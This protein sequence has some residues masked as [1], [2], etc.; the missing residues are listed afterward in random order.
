MR[1]KLARLIF[2]ACMGV[3]LLTCGVMTALLAHWQTD[4]SREQLR[5]YSSAL[6]AMAD[7]S[8]WEILR[9]LPAE[10][11]F[12]TAVRGAEGGILWE[13][14]P[15]AEKNALCCT[16]SLA[17][18]EI[19]EVSA[20]GTGPWMLVPALVNILVTTLMLT[21]ILSLLLAERF[22]RKI[23]APISTLNVEN[24]DDAEIYEEMKPFVRRISFQNRQIHQ[25]MDA[26]LEE[27]K[28]Q[29][30]MRREFTA[31]VSHE[32]KTPL[33]SISGFAEII[34]DG[35]VQ[36]K[37]IPHFADTI[38]QEAQRLM[39]LVNDILKLSRLEEG[40]DEILG[41]RETVEL[42]A[43]C[44]EVME[45]LEM[46]A[47]KHGVSMEISGEPVCT[48]GVRNMLDEIVYNV[49]DN[50]IKYNRRGGIVRIRT[51]CTGEEAYVRIEDT[52]I[53]IPEADR[54][55]IFER[56]YRVNKSHSKE[57]GGTGLGLSI[58]KHGMA[59]HNARITLESEEEKG[60]AVG[61]YFIGI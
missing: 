48:R 9:S 36:E 21:V 4:R 18:G 54:T 57:V 60:T 38:Y 17:G 32:L 11:R 46:S 31:N 22:S 25:Q 20:E 43:L 39:V 10:S 28:R 15:P 8:G 1:N 6:T 37:D 34:R 29:D 49:C 52:G 5:E 13:S 12:R 41:E 23:M 2:I 55:R 47:R 50:A 56:F 42:A 19:L 44:R 61:L 24:P 33:T 3:F 58:V 51:G 7:A 14:A 26:L 27:H 53:G 40:S 30:A 16:V 45:R 35:F 59:Y